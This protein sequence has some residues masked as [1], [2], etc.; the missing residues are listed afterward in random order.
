MTESAPTY[1]FRFQR[2][3]SERWEELNPVLGPAEPGV[4]LDTGLFKIGDGHTEWND[5]DYYL[6]ELYI[7]GLIEVQLAETGGLSSDPRVGDLEELTTTARDT[8]V[9]AINEVNATASQ[10]TGLSADVSILQD[11]VAETPLYVPFG[12][13]GNL[14]PFIG[15][16]IYFNDDVQ[17]VSS[18]F[19]LTTAPTGSSAIFEILKNGAPTHSSDPVIPPS[20]FIASAGTLAVPT[21]FLGRVDYL[22]IQCLQVGSSLPGSDLS[23]LLKLIP[24]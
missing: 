3:T 8:L 21:I 13:N 9:E 4:E 1:E 7:T 17:L 10:I 16:K 12:R 23:V 6:T 14:I 18:T 19:S 15:P 11:V 24:A 20:G 5:L 2:G 22:Q